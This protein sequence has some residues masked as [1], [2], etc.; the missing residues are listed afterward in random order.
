VNANTQE[1]QVVVLAD[2][3][4]AGSERAYPVEGTILEMR[5]DGAWLVEF[6]HPV[7]IAG[8]A[9]RR[10]VITPRHVGYPLRHVFPGWLRGL[11]LSVPGLRRLSAPLVAVNVL[12]EDGEFLATASVYLKA[13][14]V[15]C[16]KS[17]RKGGAV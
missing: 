6:E 13:V 8:Q 12:D 14:Y 4:P 5:D 9:H 1:G 11:L 15:K 16:G 2:W 10:A 7:D 17:G 3:D